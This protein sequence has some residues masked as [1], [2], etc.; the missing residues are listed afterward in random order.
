MSNHTAF[1]PAAQ[2]ATLNRCP[3]TLGSMLQK[4]IAAIA[5]PILLCLILVTAT[6]TTQAQ[7]IPASYSPWDELTAHPL[8]TGLL[9]C[10]HVV[11]PGTTTETY[12]IYDYSARWDAEL[13]RVYQLL[14]QGSNPTEQEQI[15][16]AQRLWVRLKT[17]EFKYIAQRYDG[18]EGTM[19][20]W[21]QALDELMFIRHRT[22]ELST[23]LLRGTEN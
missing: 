1:M 5:A 3:H 13:N 10:M 2:P 19:Y 17:V 20:K 4:S 16:A 14:L 18:K 6:I 22:L 15:R 21:M 11:Q 7:T 23:Y 8:D 12:C 9:H